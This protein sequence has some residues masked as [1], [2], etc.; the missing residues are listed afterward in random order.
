MKKLLFAFALL[1][2]FAPTV[3]AY[4]NQDYYDM[5]HNLESS[6]FRDVS[7]TSGLRPILDWAVEN[8]YLDAGGF[9]RPD[10]AIP[11]QM[12]WPLVL[13]EAGFD[14]ESAT[15]NTPLPVNIAEE[16][17]M[18]QFLREAIRRG[19]I[20]VDEEFDGTKDITQL[21][22]L[23]TLIETKAILVPS[24]TSAKFRQLFP[25][26]PSRASY[27]PSLEAAYAS[28]MFSKYEVTNFKPTKIATRENV[29]TWLYRYAHDGV[30]KSTL[31]INGELK[32]A[33][34]SQK[35]AEE[36][37]PVRENALQK[38]LSNRRTNTTQKKKTTVQ[39]EI[40]NDSSLPSSKI[41]RDS[42]RF[43]LLEQV[44]NDV[45]EKYRFQE[46]LTV[47]KK[48]EMIEA[49]TEAM[50]KALGDKYSS[51][52]KP[53][54]SKD[55]QEGLNGEFEGIGAYIE[56][57]DGKFTITA[58]ITGSPAEEFGIQAGDVVLKVDDVDIK[59]E[60][61]V[62]SV[63]RIKGPAGT[64][65]TLTIQRTSGIVNITLPRGKITVPSVTL[66]WVKTIPVLGI[67]QFNH[68]TAEDLKDKIENIVLPKN[69]R[70]VII[71]LRN[72][73][74]GFLTEA[75][76][77]GEIFL[78]KDDVVFST[79]YENRNQVYKAGKTGIKSDMT[80][81]IILQN[82]GTASAS[83][84]IIKALKDYGRAITLGLPT[85]GKGTVQSVSQYNNGGI[86]KVT[87]AKWLSP[88]GDW[89]GGE[90]II[91]DIEVDNPTVKQ[92][93]EVV[94]P[95]I[96]RAVQKMLSW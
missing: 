42:S 87:I 73:P 6:H 24:R 58:P 21:E 90:G 2:L 81:I 80:K 35:K 17:E 89:L 63:N 48:K 40:L 18:A 74:G 88:K 72:N 56:M 13:K 38:Y 59:G 65:V 37:E 54:M 51:Y 14:P 49:A 31:D 82:K 55:F 93:Q 86:L 44:Y 68:D 1:A 16:D 23:E 41:S 96:D 91:P 12:F 70:G 39:I 77:V 60:A 33:N 32:P 5:R 11:A 8:N 85:H 25:K 26:L 19:F 84:I 15:F 27:L 28:N 94:D 20:N 71:D 79:E 53:S 45:M 43:D 57:L 67:H 66:K 50:V 3:N 92:K 76:K 61:L 4:Q 34:I 22:A 69:P 64:K 83:E 47:E 9:F 30:K 7:P 46:N 36:V 29:V 78:K 75:V 10:L 62:D 95:Q 52:I